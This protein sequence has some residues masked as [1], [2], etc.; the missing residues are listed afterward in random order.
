MNFFKGWSQNQKEKKTKKKK[1]DGKNLEGISW[2][3]KKHTTTLIFA[4]ELAFSLSAAKLFRRLLSG[5]PWVLPVWLFFEIYG[6]ESSKLRPR[7]GLYK[8]LPSYRLETGIYWQDK[9]QYK[10]SMHAKFSFLLFHFILKSKETLTI[11]L[12]TPNAHP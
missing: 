11:L 9:Q 7:T 2:E 1:K 4:T 12:W 10:I 5:K 3:H 8:K 6:S